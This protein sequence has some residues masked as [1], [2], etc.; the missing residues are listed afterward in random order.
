MAFYLGWNT[1]KLRIPVFGETVPVD[2]E[3]ELFLHLVSFARSP[4]LSREFR[5]KGASPSSIA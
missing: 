1:L 3:L 4:P 5:K 2:S